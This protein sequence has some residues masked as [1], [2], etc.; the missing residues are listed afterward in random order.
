M[1]VRLL[2][3]A[4]LTSL[5]LGGC[6]TSARDAVKAKVEQYAQATRDHD[7]R[8][9]CT[10]VL[11]PAIVQRLNG[12]G[13]GCEQAMAI[14]YNSVKDATLGV[15]KITVHGKSASVVVLSLAA[16][17]PST[18]ATILLVD[19]P[20]GWRISSEHNPVGTGGG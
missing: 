2:V 5:A 18:L 8:T 14:A 9:I 20:H 4:L 16:N 6:G 1:S 3:V 7:Y 17:Q 11:A 10:Q 15:G 12:Y 13:V 19:T